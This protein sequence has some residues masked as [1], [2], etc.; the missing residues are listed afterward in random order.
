MD[1]AD[2][3]IAD[4][5]RLALEADWQPF[6]AEVLEKLCAALGVNHAAWWTH[7]VGRRGGVLNQYPESL[8]SLPA[9]TELA[10]AVA[11]GVVDTSAGPALLLRVEHLNEALVSAVLLV[12]SVRDQVF[13]LPRVVGHMVEAGA[14]ALHQFIR[15][16]DWLASLGRQSRGSAALVSADGTVFAASDNFRALVNADG[17]VPFAIPDAALGNGGDFRHQGVHLRL[18]RCGPLYLMHARKPLPLDQLSPREQEIARA[19]SR[20][21]TLKSIA[22]EYGIAV[23]TVAN[24][25]TRIYRKLSI[26]RREDLIELVRTPPPLPVAKA[27]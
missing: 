5:Y 1:A 17:A 21:K 26:Y 11:S 27:Q 16:D 20:G 24:H 13:P 6:R 3:L 4:F 8:I 18:S 23:S 25:T 7:G 22:R 9:L 12:G 2:R 19:L 15:R 10:A 14:V